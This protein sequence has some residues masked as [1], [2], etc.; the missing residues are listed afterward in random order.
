[1]GLLY[2][3]NITRVSTLGKSRCCDHHRD[4]QNSAHCHCQ[5]KRYYDK[6]ACNLSLLVPQQTVR[7]QTP[8]DT[9]AWLPLKARLM[10]L[11][12]VLLVLFSALGCNLDFVLYKN[13]C[14][15]IN[16]WYIEIS[17]LRFVMFK[18]SQHGKLCYQY[19]CCKKFDLNILYLIS[20]ILMHFT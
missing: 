10:V 1:M 2:L 13:L 7:M 12:N 5:Q 15:V 4:A 9:T 3:C 14:I 16:I 8:R 20:T 6:S 17:D 19:D 18:Y 11:S